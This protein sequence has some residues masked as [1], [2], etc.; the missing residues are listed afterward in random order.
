MLISTL[1]CTIKNDLFH[2]SLVVSKYPSFFFPFLISIIK[3][4]LIYF[5]SH[6]RLFQ[7]FNFN[8]PLNFFRN[9]LWFIEYDRTIIKFRWVSRW[10]RKICSPIT[11]SNLLAVVMLIISWLYF[12]WSQTNF[13]SCSKW[14]VRSDLDI[15]LS[16]SPCQHQVYL[17]G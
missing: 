2:I 10:R 3:W 6:L 7:N 17:L 8:Y 12:N 16:V 13:A 1:S 14:Y 11:D 15:S 9:Q 4:L 5:S